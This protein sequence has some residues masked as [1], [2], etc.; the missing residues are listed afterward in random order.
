MMKSELL[1]EYTP[2]FRMQS[3]YDGWKAYEQG[4]Y[5]CP[6]NANSVDAQAWDRGLEA[7]MRWLN[8]KV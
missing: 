7:A 6:Y 8:R 5:Q 4:N 1:A 2:Y 3:F